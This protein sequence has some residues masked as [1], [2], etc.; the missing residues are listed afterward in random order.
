MVIKPYAEQREHVC[1]M[2]VGCGYQF[3]IP[4]LDEWESSRKDVLFSVYTY[5][6]ILYGKYLGRALTNNLSNSYPT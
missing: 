5:A 6:C 1:R 3:A 4:S 2:N